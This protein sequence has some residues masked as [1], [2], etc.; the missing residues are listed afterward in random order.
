[1]TNYLVNTTNSYHYIDYNKQINPI[2]NDMRTTYDHGHRNYICN[3]SIAPPDN[4]T[5]NACRI[6][7]NKEMRYDYLTENQNQFA[8]KLPV[9]HFQKADLAIPCYKPQFIQDAQEKTFRN[10]PKAIKHL[11]SYNV[12]Y[13]VQPAAFTEMPVLSKHIYK[14]PA[15]SEDVIY[16]NQPGHYK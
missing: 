5:K 16:S 1:M 2:K 3:D 15:R 11:S 12:D 9:T 4:L 10:P 13:K 14:S 7:G 6:I 8:W